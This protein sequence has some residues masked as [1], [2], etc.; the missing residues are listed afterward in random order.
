LQ[1]F[2]LKQIESQNKSSAHICVL[3]EGLRI[4]NAKIVGGLSGFNI[5]LKFSL[6]L[7]RFL[8]K[9]EIVF[10]FLLGN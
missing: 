10:K 4:T 3:K 2:K 7:E 9:K 5:H 1:E 8:P 6:K